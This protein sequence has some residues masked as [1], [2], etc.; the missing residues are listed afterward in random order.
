MQTDVTNAK[1]AVV[2]WETANATATA[3]PTG[4]LTAATYGTYGFT[5]STNTKTLAFSGSATFPQFCIAGTDQNTASPTTY[6]VTDST[7]ITTTKPATC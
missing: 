5:Q 1:I 2:A 3:F 6:Y 7:G 4:G